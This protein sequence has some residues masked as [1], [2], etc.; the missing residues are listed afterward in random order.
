LQGS[1][2]E[3]CGSECYLDDVAHWVHTNDIRT[4]SFGSDLSGTQSITLYTVSTFGG[5]VNI[6]KS[7]AKYGGFI[8]SNDNDLPDLASEW[9]EDSDGDPDNYFAADTSTE[10]TAGLNTALYD[11]L[12]R[13]ASGSAISVLSTSEVGEGA[14]YQAYFYGKNIDNNGK[15]ITW[16]G[17]LLG[18]FIDE[19]GN[20][21]EDSNTND[22]L[23]M[24]SDKI[25]V[26]YFD[27]GENRTRIK[28]Y[29]D[30]DGDGEADGSATIME[31]EDIKSLWDA[32]KML[33][34]TTPSSR[35]IYTWIDSDTAGTIGTVD[36]GEFASSLFATTNKTALRPFL[37]AATDTVAEKIV[38]YVRGTDQTGYRSREIDVDGTDRTWKLGDI[39][40]STPAVVGKP[41]E[42]YDLI[43]GDTSYATFKNTYKD[44]RNV[45]YVGANDGML[46]AFNGGF[47]NTSAHQFTAGTGKS[48]GEELWAY[49]PYNL[50][51]HLQWLTDTSY[52]HVY[53]VDLKPKVIDARIFSDDATHP[54]GWGTVLV[55][56]MRFGG[57]EISLT[58]DF[59][60]GSST[61][62][63]FRS[64]Y[65]ALDIT[66]PESAPDLLWEFTHANLGYTTS[67]PAVVY[68]D[69]SSTPGTWWIAFGSGPTDFDGTS[70][71]LGQ[72]FVVNLKTGAMPNNSPIGTNWGSSNY[73]FK[74]DPI[75]VDVDI[76]DSQC[77][78]GSCSYSPDVF[79]IGCSQGTLWRV[80]CIGG[81]WAGTHSYLVALGN[82]KPITA[83]PSASQDDDGRLWLYFGTGRFFTETDKTDTVTQSLVGVK[84]PYDWSDCDSDSVYRELTIY[85]NSCMSAVAATSSN[86]LDVTDYAVYENGWVDEDDDG[87]ADTTFNAL[88]NDMYQSSSVDTHYDGW[89]LDITSGERC[90]TK[91]TVLGGMVTFSTYE[92]IADVCTYEGNSYL[93]ALYYKT[94]TAFAEN[95]IGSDT[96]TLDTGSGT[97]SLERYKRRVSLGRG[98]SAS[99]SLH[100]GSQKGAKVILQTST[101]QILQIQESN[102]P[103]SYK[104]CPLAGTWVQN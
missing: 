85:C 94:G 78:G 40:Y 65:F 49:I 29:L 69:P 76:S 81:T 93:Y 50:L 75:S 99:P 59:G 31:I 3:T 53:Y 33:A 67:Y 24:T 54:G 95:I 80:S 10:L 102:L 4:S 11:I 84:E 63:T 92:P 104:S 1:I 48:L 58:D 39:I 55:C 43:Y 17:Y 22:T 101:G 87:T 68:T 73:S 35:T 8:D 97:E 71:Q 18:L 21:R 16:P 34:Q 44:R 7:A 72:T 103:D 5:G 46:H 62:R 88:V 12:N 79:Y 60:S 47:F 86:L 38:G 57:G 77:S 15:E 37:D 25:I 90:I 83:A 56:G 82:T 36:S 61:T 41:A 96:D 64:A 32:G 27:E 52:S 19:Y 66:D 9:D 28:Q 30:S 74:G 70:T 45:I 91:P 42:S 23:D 26:Y 51:P 100:I 13:V 89:I 6:L 14:V 2:G 20:I 98:V